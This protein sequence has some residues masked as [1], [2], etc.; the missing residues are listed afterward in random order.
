MSQMWSWFEG[1]LQ[2]AR[3]RELDRIAAAYAVGGWL[4]VQAASIALPAFD[5][6]SWLL[7]WL[8]AALVVGFPTVLISV[9]L[10]KKPET[11]SWKLA[12]FRSRN[13]IF[14]S[15]VALVA[16]LTLAELAW[17]WSAGAALTGS[18]QANSAA[19]NSIAV[20]PFDN[21][22]GDPRQRYFSEG[23]SSELIGLLARNPALRVAAR[24]S[25][26][27]FEGK[28]QDIRVIAQ[29]LN[30]RAILE[31]SVQSDGSHLHI[32]TSLV[33]AA[34]GYQLWSQSYDRSLSDVLSVQA[35]I[36]QSIAQALAPALTGAKAS[37]Q[38]PKPTQIDPQ[39]YREYLQAQVY[40]DQRMSE[41][42][43][44]ES[45]QAIDNS[46][47]LL[48]RVASAVPNFADGQAALAQALFVAQNDDEY[49]GQ[50]QQAV[51]RALALDPENPQALLVSM[52]VAANNKDWDSAIAFAATLK[53]HSEH[54]AVGAEGLAEI[55]EDLYLNEQALA[56][57]KEWAKL[58]PFSVDAWQGT[59]R[60][61]FALARYKDAIAANDQAL[62]LHPDD[63]VTREYK[64]VS[65][66]S[67]N[68]IDAAKEVLS[69][70]SRPGVPAPLASHC[71]F[72]ITL[73]S[74]G[75][76]PAVA[77]VNNALAHDK[78][79]LG[80]PGDVGFMLSH[81]GADDEAMDWYQKTYDAGGFLSGFYPGE[82]T[83]AAFFQNPRW[84]AFT[85]QPG[86]QKRE[87][88]RVRAL[89]VLGD[90]PS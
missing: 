36:A 10:L 59:A 5:A 41:Q 61:N 55:Y 63:P 52:N 49:A 66:A 14:V 27:F 15:L 73:H 28:E 34:N 77:L 58:D 71:R 79:S 11:E 19:P 86:Y 90:N 8:I 12:H 42:Q 6:P 13:A 47:A 72:F 56:A 70:I 57:Y 65:L 53:R 26:F 87:A 62:A 30:V 84:I 80:P 88:A 44:P 48:R 64:C 74:Q 50:I 40:F 54:T 85:K 17:H 89:Q 21:M 68:K 46:I 23:I 69:E 51:S 7:R 67:L 24:T 43:T 4:F 29:K 2:A 22:S 76:A 16:V 37:P 18:K 78:D 45:Q 82:S 35:Q 39:V 31:G 83:P 38:I 20:L 9:W 60:V 81:A 1:A 3:K 75:A 25:S 32:E 33:N